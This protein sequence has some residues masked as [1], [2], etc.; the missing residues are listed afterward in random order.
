MGVRGPSGDADR[1]GAG[2]LGPR[3]V[4][5]F[6]VA[7]GALLIQQ[8]LQIGSTVGYSVVGPVTIPLVVS[9]TLLVLGLILA[10]RTTVLVDRDLATLAAEEERATHWN[11]VG[12]TLAILLV[13]AIALN[14]VRL[15]PVAIPGLGY[16]VATGLFL[17]ATAWV[18]GSRHLVRDVVIGFGVAVIVYVSFTEFL[19]VR[20]PSGVLGIIR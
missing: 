12:V 4:A 1:Q 5:L 9:G 8:A 13:Y 18:L 7:L 15:G 17:P 19:G 6:L 20:L 10:V 14:G 3:I 16:V 11:T 2:L